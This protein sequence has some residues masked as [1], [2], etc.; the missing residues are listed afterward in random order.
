M[1]RSL[2]NNFDKVYDYFGEY[3]LHLL[4]WF[5]V[6]Y[7]AVIFGIVTLDIH[8]LN[9]FNVFMHSLVCIFLILRF[10]P[11]RDK[12]KLRPNDS[13]IIF[14][15]SLF[16]L[17]NM[18]I[19]EVIKNFFPDYLVN[20]QGIGSSSGDFTDRR[21]VTSLEDLGFSMPLRGSEKPS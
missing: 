7:F 5:H 1:F 4:F 19:V 18:G 6:T 12:N 9:S 3:Y 10:N 15:S 17:L 21:S 2:I 13:N 20:I 14:S 16:L 11:L 8:L